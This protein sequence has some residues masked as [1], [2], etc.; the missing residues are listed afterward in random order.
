MNRI[1]TPSLVAL[2]LAGC[3]GSIQRQTSDARLIAWG[4][5]DGVSLSL[6]SLATARVIH[7]T[8]AAMAAKDLHEAT[9]DLTAAD[10]AVAS[11][12]FS[13]AASNVASANK[14]ISALQLIVAQNK[15][16]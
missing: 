15:G 7:G 13:S 16:H 3:A 2:A 8:T 10:T 5:L 1:I 9:A 4:A 14:L 6:D 11:L 12:N